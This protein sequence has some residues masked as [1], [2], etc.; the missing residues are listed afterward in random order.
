[1]KCIHGLRVFLMIGVAAC[2]AGC[3]SGSGSAPG[4]STT[5]AQSGSVYVLG[6]DAP[7]PSVVSF[8]VSLQ[9]ITLSNGSATPVS[10]LNGAQTVD[11]AR[12]N[13]LST[14]LDFNSI[15]TGTYTTATITL[16]SATLG[17]LNTQ[18]GTPPTVA[19]M[20]A[21]LTQP[22]VT[23]NLAS[24]FV[25]NAGDMDALRFDF[26]LQQSVQVDA[27][28]QITGQ[29]TPTLDLKALSASDPENYI[30]EFDAGVVSIDA[31]ANSF[32]IQ[33]PHG[34]QYTV[35]LS[36]NTEFENNESI[37]NLTTNSIIEVSGSFAPNSQTI[38]ADCLGILS[39]DGYW[40]AG[41]ITNV[42]PAQGAANGFGIYVRAELPADTGLTLGQIAKINLTGSENY[43]IYKLH[44]PLTNFFFNSSLLVPGQHVSIGGPLSG[45]GNSQ[46]VTA[47]R[48]VLRHE[49]H[50]GEWVSGST[51]TGNGT[52]QFNSN[53]L[54]GV[55]FN[56]PVTVYTTPVTN[57]LG[58]LTGLSDLSG[59]SAIS[60]RVVGLVL[61]NPSTGNP[62]F[63]ARS[64][65]ELQ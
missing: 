1:M 32:V 13:G 51:N 23:I 65:E 43:F 59:N 20:P 7:L 5:P 55:L 39:Q 50:T 12:F 18:S 31:S 52:F 61:K 54:A 58:G 49:G 60:I 24:P 34:R 28:G 11:F 15:P 47:H 56:G 30:D 46:S 27:N 45:A 48:I 33:G 63:V 40:A 3:S 57:W 42:T 4:S 17:Y 29:V 41:L 16:G 37:A 21:T 14:L 36:S 10:I 35:Q 62:V 53:G 64:V 26:N 44:T 9:S 2:V 6:T 22:V 8:A 38:N 19:S 25:V